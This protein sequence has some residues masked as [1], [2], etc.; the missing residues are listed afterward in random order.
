MG[1]NQLL[2]ER[3]GAT[4]G[5]GVFPPLLLNGKERKGH[6]AARRAARA[7]PMGG[8]PEYHVATTRSNQDSRDSDSNLPR[9]CVLCPPVPVETGR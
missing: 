8:L 1:A 7:R 5:R 6:E 2:Q 3:G 9:L 4:R